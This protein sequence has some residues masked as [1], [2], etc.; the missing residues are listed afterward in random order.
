MTLLVTACATHP[1]RF[2]F[3]GTSC[4]AFYNTFLHLGSSRLLTGGLRHI[5]DGRGIEGHIQEGTIR[6][7]CG[8][9]MSSGSGDG[10][11]GAVG[12]G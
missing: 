1:Q 6:L 10:A 8:K 3:G 11:C 2:R 7:V 12:N 5:H 4:S 9:S